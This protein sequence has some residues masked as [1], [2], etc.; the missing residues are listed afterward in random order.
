MGQ[1]VG[2]EE[3]QVEAQEEDM[4]TLVGLGFGALEE[5]SW[6]RDL[7]IQMLLKK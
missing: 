6:G 4:I 7:E 5:A 2:Q 1:K 3:G